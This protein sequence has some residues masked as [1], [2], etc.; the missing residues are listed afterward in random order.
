[1]LT[2][3][4]GQSQAADLVAM[5]IETNETGAHWRTAFNPIQAREWVAALGERHD[6]RATRATVE[7][8]AT[9]LAA[10]TG[11]YRMPS[12]QLLITISRPEAGGTGAEAPGHS[13]EATAPGMPVVAL[14]AESPTT[15]F[16]KE[17]NTRFEFVVDVDA[18]VTGLRVIWSAD[19]SEVAPRVE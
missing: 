12:S 19:R 17:D 18:R 2:G 3:H 10:Y 15:F 6:G 14:Y 4:V 13:L 11:Q 8:P 7:V 9:R 16:M 1:M 5:L